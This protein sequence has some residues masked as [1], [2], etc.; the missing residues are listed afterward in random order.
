MVKAVEVNIERM[1]FGHIRQVTEIERR[2]FTNTWPFGAFFSELFNR[3]AYYVVATINEKVVGFAGMWVVDEEA[4]IT[5]IAVDPDWRGRKIGERLLLHLLQEA[6]RRGAEYAILEVRVSNLI[7]QNLYHKY[8]F[9]IAYTRKGYY[10]DNNEDAFVM[11]LDNLQSKD[12]GLMLENFAKKL[13]EMK[14]SGP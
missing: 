3:R 2:S 4:H 9:K 14:E 13:A 11:R 8:N 5:T 1:R 6:R 12:V 10:S 7:A